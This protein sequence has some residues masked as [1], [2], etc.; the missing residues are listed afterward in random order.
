MSVWSSEMSVSSRRRSRW[1]SPSSVIRRLVEREVLEPG[2]RFEQGERLVGR[3]GLVEVHADHRLAGQR[4]VAEDLASQLLDRRDGLR[5]IARRLLGPGGRDVRFAAGRSPRGRGRSRSEMHRLRRPPAPRHANVVGPWPSPV[6]RVDMSSRSR[7]IVAGRSRRVESVEVDGRGGFHDDQMRAGP[8]S[9]LRRARF[10]VT[11]R[12]RSHR[13]VTNRLDVPA[14][15]LAAVVGSWPEPAILESGPGFGD[16]GRW[17]IFAA[18][19]RLVFEA[20]GIALVDHRPTTGSV[21][22]RRGRS[23]GGPR[24]AR[25]AVRIWP[26]R[27]SEPDPDAAAV[28]G[29]ADRLHRLRPGPAARTPAAPVAA[30]LADARYPHGTLRHGRLRRCPH[31]AGSSSGPGT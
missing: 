29:R 20:T 11:T 24:R 8:R 6:L 14:D 18:H 17:S 26:I 1:A 12:E 31:R 7:P 19:P 13:L 16:A 30:R 25:A 3:A 2:E 21:E 28:P 5:L 27:P 15:R 23:A 10:P 9:R 4:A 22:T